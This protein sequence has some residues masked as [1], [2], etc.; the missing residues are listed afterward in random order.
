[1]K[2]YLRCKQ[3]DV[4]IYINTK[5]KTRCELPDSFELTCNHGHKNDYYKYE[6]NAEAEVSSPTIGII[7]GGLIGSALAGGIG[8]VGGAV[9][10]ASA[11]SIHTEK[12]RKATTRFN[13]S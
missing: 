1:M 11:G 7:L 8:A 3:C 12:E 2:Y 13:K 5:A 9:I 10:L 4:N 6:V